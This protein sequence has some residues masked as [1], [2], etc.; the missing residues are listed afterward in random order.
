MGFSVLVNFCSVV[1]VFSSTMAAAVQQSTLLGKLASLD[2][3]QI[4]GAYCPTKLFIGGLSQYTTSKGLRDYFSTYGRVLDCVAMTKKEGGSARNFGFVTLQTLASAEAALLDQHML[5]GHVLDVKPTED[6]KNGRG[7][8]RS[9]SSELGGAAQPLLRPPPG[10]ATGTGGLRSPPGLSLLPRSLPPPPGLAA[11]P[12]Q[13]QG[14]KKEDLEEDSA[15]TA[16]P[17]SAS[18][19]DVESDMEEAPQQSQ[20]EAA[21]PQLPSLGSMQH[22]A[23]TCKPCN[24]FA[25]GVCESGSNCTFCHLT[26]EKRRPTRQEKRDRKA[27]WLQKHT[28]TDAA[29]AADTN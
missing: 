26:H 5:N 1:V 12:P 8:R 21:S 27:D 25:R 23:G 17:S 6:K 4:K 11:L 2:V 9:K 15:S 24:F 7:D 18:T 3:S 10:L 20:K 28:Q 29:A 22:A 14:Q 16:P 19:C 13:T